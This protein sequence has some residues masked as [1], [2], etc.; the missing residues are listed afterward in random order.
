MTNTADNLGGEVGRWF[1]ERQHELRVFAASY[2]VAENLPLSTA[3]DA[4][5][6]GRIGDYLQAVVLLIDSLPNCIHFEHLKNQ[7]PF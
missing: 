5:A 1:L 4:E 7:M 6:T 3:G 2:V